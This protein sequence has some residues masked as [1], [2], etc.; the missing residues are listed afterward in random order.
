MDADKAVSAR[1]TELFVLSGGSTPTAGISVDDDL[2]VL[3]NGQPLFTDNDGQDNSEFGENGVLDPIQF[4]ASNGDILTITALDVLG[5]CRDLS[6]GLSLHRISD[7]SAQSIGGFPRICGT[8]GGETFYTN[9]VT[10]SFP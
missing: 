8:N 10:I 7:N 5:G 1:F 4:S 3:L 2:S 9:S 6:P